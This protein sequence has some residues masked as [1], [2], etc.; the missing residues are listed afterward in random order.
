MK[1][2]WCFVI[3]Y[4]CLLYCQAQEEVNPA[5]KSVFIT[6]FPFTQYSGGVMVVKA[7]FGSVKDTLH[8]ILDTGCAGISLDS[9]TCAFYHI[10]TVPTDTIVNG[11]GGSHKVR[12]IF[13]EA[14]HL[15]GLTLTNLNFHINDYSL[16]SGVYGEKIN[17]IIGYSFFKRYIVKMDFDSSVLEVYTPGRMEYPKGGTIT[18]PA[19]N[20]L[21]VQRATV[22]DRKKFNYNFYFDTGAGLCFLMS[23]AFATDSSVLLK[24]RKPVELQVE[25]MGGKLAVKFTVIKFVQIGKYRFDNVPTYIYDDESNVTAFPG[26]GGLVG[27][28]LLRR[29]N[30]TVNYPAGEIHLLPN[31]HFT[32]PFDYAY[33]GLGIYYDDGTIYIEDVMAHSPGEKAGIMPGDILLGVNT[34]FSNNIVQYKTLLQSAKERIMLSISRNGELKRLPV[35]PG[36]IF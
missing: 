34:N 16:L 32:D 10:P 17:G 6:R 13:N 24:R 7:T 33:T 36:T 12:Y 26:N 30:L 9:S 28:D 8:F 25:G 19:I 2:F 4:C 14:L 31:S 5:Q 20:R 11:M 27:I 21:P 29:F 23:K 35:Y 3:F 1:S 15:Q 18:R 22:R